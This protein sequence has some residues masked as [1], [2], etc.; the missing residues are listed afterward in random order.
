MKKYQII[1]HSNG[2][3]ITYDTVIPMSSSLTPEQ[4]V[5]SKGITSKNVE[6][7]QIPD[8]SQLEVDE[9]MIK[10]FI[11]ETDI[12]K[13]GDG[14]HEEIEI[15]VE[16]DE[17]GDVK[18]KK[19]VNGVEVEMT[20]VELEDIKTKHGKHGKIIEMRMNDS[21]GG[22]K[23][24]HVEISVKIDDAGNVVTKKIVN[25]EEVEMTEQEL[26]D[27][28]VFE[29]NGG[30]DIQLF[31]DHES[32]ENELRE[33]ELD[34]ETLMEEEGEHEQII[35]K[36]IDTHSGGHDDINWISEDGEQHIR[37]IS[38]DV[39]D[40]TI[41]L[42]T[43]NYDENSTAKANIMLEESNSNTSIFP[44]PND[45]AFRI[46]YQSDEAVKTKITV[47]DAKGKK[48]FE[49]N[50]GKFSGKYDKEVN[51]KEFG[52]GTYTITIESGNNKEVNKVIVQ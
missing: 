24:E 3:T 43:E 38:S 15:S 47:T 1:H 29:M 51:L 49:D 7:I 25:G 19:I 36:R 41:V 12:E 28:H 46:R 10:T 33:L 14:K 9:K 48:V 23:E 40:H 45:G 50:L 52:S 30:E 2:E 21:N 6:V 5:A 4:F 31:I 39:E 32:L 26:E 22:A 35:V 18:T 42:V 27:L 37:V 13:D 20:E 16:I 8:L 44:N 11:R 34:I 17:N